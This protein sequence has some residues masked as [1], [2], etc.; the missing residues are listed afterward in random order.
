[1]AVELA[2]PLR[3][4]GVGGLRISEV[5]DSADVAQ[6]LHVHLTT[7]QELTRRGQ[8]PGR[9]VGK[10]YRY[11]REAVLGWLASGGAASEASR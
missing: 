1:M 4:V 6:L 11:L 10:D 2:Q 3:P 8:L 9:K 5:I 7:V